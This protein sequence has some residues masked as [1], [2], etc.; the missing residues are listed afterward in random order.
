MTSIPQVVYTTLDEFDGPQK[1]ALI[2]VSNLHNTQCNKHSG[3]D[4]LL[5]ISDNRFVSCVIRSA[6]FN[7]DIKFMC[8]LLKIAPK[9]IIIIDVDFMN[10]F[11]KEIYYVLA[12]TDCSNLSSLIKVFRTMWNDIPVHA[13]HIAC[14]NPLFTMFDYNSIR[15]INNEVVDEY[16]D[17]LTSLGPIST[18][19][20]I[21]FNRKV[22]I[23]YNTYYKILEYYSKCDHICSGGNNFSDGH[24]SYF[25]EDEIINLI[26]ITPDAYIG[27]Y[28]KNRTIKMTIAFLE[29]ADMYKYCDNIKHWIKHG[30]SSNIFNSRY[31]ELCSYFHVAHIHEDMEFNQILLAILFGYDSII[32]DIGEKIVTAFVYCDDLKPVP[33]IIIA[34]QNILLKV[35]NHL[36]SAIRYINT[37]SIT[38]AL[39]CK[40]LT[41]PK[42]K[43]EKE[44]L[45]AD[46]RRYYFPDF[47]S[48]SQCLQHLE[49]CYFKGFNH[50]NRV[51]QLCINNPNRTLNVDCAHMIRTTPQSLELTQML[52]DVVHPNSYTAQ[53]DIERIGIKYMYYSNEELIKEAFESNSCFTFMMYHKSHYKLLTEEHY[54]NALKWELSIEHIPYHMRSARI[55]LE[56][57]KYSSNKW[58]VYWIPLEHRTNELLMIYGN[59]VQRPLKYII[60]VSADIDKNLIQYELDNIPISSY[61]RAMLTCAL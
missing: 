45:Y 40:L 30:K 35:S 36:C 44:Y 51:F 18:F 37:E 14:M 42:D 50:M 60:S 31:T 27:V 53:Y 8:M 9:F 47:V 17:I 5:G 10:K 15:Q 28:E 57:S 22:R 61:R 41:S 49:T 56:A 34:Q 19:T 38:D 32:G 39:C 58:N 16:I 1:E 6:M 48:K 13:R 59:L 33:S 2:Y 46:G 25:S 26:K 52:F 4:D 7:D 3:S 11:K 12:L 23:P 24:Y 20:A 54:F 43:N 55:C 29:H 21:R